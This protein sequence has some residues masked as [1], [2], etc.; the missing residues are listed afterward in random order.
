MRRN[1]NRKAK[2]L[3][4][5]IAAVW[6]NSDLGEIPIGHLHITASYIVRRRRASYFKK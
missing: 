1:A 2:N 4:F 6:S 5:N 3:D